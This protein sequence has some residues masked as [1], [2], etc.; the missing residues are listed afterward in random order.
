MNMLCTHEKSFRGEAGMMRFQQARVVICGAGAL[1]SNIAETLIRCG[2]R[3]LRVIDN[4]RVEAHNLTTQTYGRADIGAQKVNA[5]RHHLYR[6][7]GIEIDAVPR[8][9][10]V[11]NVKS[12]LRAADLIIDTFDNSAAR[13][14]VS[15]AARK[16]GLPCLHVGMASDYGEIIWEPDYRVPRQGTQDICDYP[17]ARNLV[18]LTAGIG[19]ET[20]MRFIADFR[21]ESYTITFNDLAVHPYVPA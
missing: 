8:A 19:A 21:R 2:F 7:S 10:N 6:V 15:V 12:L 3:H 17:L 5:L 20:V 1:G 16:Q 4:D 11:G 13:A 9:M 14:L 18:T